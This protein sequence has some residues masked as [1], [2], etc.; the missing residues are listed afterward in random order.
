MQDHR[1]LCPVFLSPLG[2]KCHA[3]S[4]LACSVLRYI[5]GAEHRAWCKVGVSWIFMELSLAYAS[6]KCRFHMS[7]LLSQS[8]GWRQEFAVPPL[9]HLQEKWI[10]TIAS[11]PWQRGVSL[12]VPIREVHENVCSQRTLGPRSTAL[13]MYTVLRHFKIMYYL[14]RNGSSR[15]TK[16][17]Q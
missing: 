5:P 10:D 14:I 2:S 15:M 11:N 3:G 13:G 4:N 6:L 1:L 7:D 12:E 16:S 17:T 8:Q 9:P